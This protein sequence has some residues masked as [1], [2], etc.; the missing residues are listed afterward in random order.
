MSQDGVTESRTL[1]LLLSREL[2]FVLVG[3]GVVLR[4]V[5]Y[6]A[7]RSLWVDEAFMALNLMDKSLGGLT[8]TLDFNQGAPIG[9]LLVEHL[10]TSAFGFSEYVLRFFPL[11]TG[12][13]SLV[14]FAALARRVL[15]PLAVPLAVLLFA[16]ADQLIYYSSEVKPYSSDVAATVL[17]LLLAVALQK[18]SPTRTTALTA[19]I[20]GALC[21]ISSNA[22][23]F[24]VAGAAAVFV[25]EAFTRLRWRLLRS[26]LP[27]IALWVASAVGVI[28]FAA[29]RLSHVRE[30]FEGGSGTFLGT[31]GSGAAS[32]LELRWASRLG[33]DVAAAMGFS[34]SRPYTQIE[35]LAAAAAL[36]GVLSLFFRNRSRGAL[37]ALPIG[38]VLLA[39][40]LNQYPLSLRTTLF[41]VPLVILFVAEGLV[42]AVAWLRRPWAGIAVT[43]LVALVIAFPSWSAAR[44]L[45]HPRTRE[46]IKTPLRYL[47]DRWRT[48]DSLYVHPGAQYALAYYLR[49]DCFGPTARANGPFEVLK[50][51]AG[52]VGQHAPALHS[53]S[54][55][56]VIGRYHGTDLEAYLRDLGRLRGNPRVWVLWSH[57][58]DE[59]GL[60]FLEH[61]LP[62][63]LDS[64]GRR[65]GEADAPR[66]HVF[67]YDLR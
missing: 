13:G 30:S 36:V 54:R 45:V 23:V 46:E 66:A 61:R 14:A 11:V 37:L 33:T 24:V 56:V 12:L 60:R 2:L 29:T 62:D 48:G 25:A 21:V 1:R 52:A 9:F 63:Y 22:A 7:D 6:A 65:L 28:A 40:A 50:R 8:R 67:L 44:H 26:H 18:S 20:V 15:L 42:R 47:S 4:V 59:R 34:Q 39:S 17:L 16:I 38:F 58:D 27:T 43:L 51:T 64:I 32:W 53:D 31:S 19:G 35:K 10:M 41:L 3:L 5:Q 49:C 55:S 57:A